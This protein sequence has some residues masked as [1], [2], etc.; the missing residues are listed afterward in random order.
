MVKKKVLFL[1]TGNSCRS[2][3]AEGF[4]RHLAKG[5]I[6]AC[7]AGITP[8]GVN[9]QAVQVMYETGVDISGQSSDALSMELL[10]DA[11]LIIT[12]CGDARESCPV[13]PGKVEKRHWPLAD[14]AKTEGSAATVL[15]SF[16]QVRDEIKERVLQLVTELKGEQDR[17]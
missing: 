5:Q 9:P 11:D 16:R 1:C 17:C 2:Q 15:Q 8:V 14:P 4:A 13:V 12:L 7:S 3:M 6:D 10:Q